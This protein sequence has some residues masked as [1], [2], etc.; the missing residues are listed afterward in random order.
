MILVFSIIFVLKLH[1]RIFKFLRLHKIFDELAEPSVELCSEGRE[2]INQARALEERKMARG[3]G[4]MAGN[5]APHPSQKTKLIDSI[6][7]SDFL[8][9]YKSAR[10]REEITRTADASDDNS[11]RS[12][13]FGSKKSKDVPLLPTSSSPKQTRNYQKL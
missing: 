8:A 6:D 13:L 12:A 5:S 3:E 10:P 7:T 11:D 1:N 4:M 2:I 9:K